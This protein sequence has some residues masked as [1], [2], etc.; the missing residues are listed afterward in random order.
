MHGERQG[1]TGGELGFEGAVRAEAE[2]SLDALVEHAP[3]GIA[4]LDR[5]LRFVRVNARLA[6]LDGVPALEHVGRRPRELLPGF[7]ADELEAEWGEVLRTG[8]P[9]V[10]VELTGETPAAPGRRRTWLVSWYPVRAGAEVVGIGGL[11][12]EVTHERDAE[13]F[14]RHVLGIVGHDLRNPLSAIATAAQLLRRARDEGAAPGGRLADRIVHNAE[15]MARIV[16]VLVDFARLRAG[17][18]MPVRPQRCDLG[19]ICRAVGEEC[20]AAHPERTVQIEVLGDTRGEWDGDR[21]AQVVA[22]L[23]ANAVDHGAPGRPVHLSCREEGAGVTVA[24]TNEGRPIPEELLPLLFEPFRR[25]ERERPGRK[26]SLGLGLFIARAITAAHGGRIDVAS[27]SPGG[28]TVFA[29]RLPR[30]RG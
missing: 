13:E 17:Q 4:F 2:A 28:P 3:I 15:R 16:S 14:Q 27:P 8:A 7:P 19:E 6:E 22:N 30:R 21:I 24:V 29:V 11:V 12:R 9:L 25:G 26:D 23:L 1:F 10:D 18:P 20:E 5:E